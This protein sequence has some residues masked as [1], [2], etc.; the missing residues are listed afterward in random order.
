MDSEV[1]KKDPETLLIK[2]ILWAL[3]AHCLWRAS[4]WLGESWLLGFVLA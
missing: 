4:S 2:V 1:S 3:A